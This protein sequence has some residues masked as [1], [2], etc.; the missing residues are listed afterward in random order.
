MQALASKSVGA[1]YVRDAAWLPHHYDPRR[2]SLTFAYLP[3]DAQRAITFLDPRFI[4]R[5]AESG[6][7]QIAQLPAG[8]IRDNA[9][10]LQFIFHTGFCCST[11][12][13][14]ALDIPGI[15]MGL[16]EPAVLASFADYWSNSRRNVGAF[17][18]LSATVDLLSRP[19]TPGE[20]QVVKPSTIV[21]HIMP[22]LLHARQDAKAILLYSSLDSFLRAIARRGV[23]GRI[24]A[25]QMFRQFAPVNP[26]DSG[27]SDDDAILFSDLQVAA[28][29]WLMQISFMDQITKRF[30]VDRIRV[31]D[32]GTLLADPA[33]TL[34]QVGAFFDMN[35]TLERAQQVASSGI[36][37]EHAKELGR[38]F[39][40]AAQKA[41][42]DEAGA[43]HRE[44]LLM[45]KDWARALAIRSNAPLA[46]PETIFS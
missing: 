45:A 42:Y 44:E 30:G 5:S 17:E 9:G 33:R 10:P 4:E 37:R 13:T 29:A 11:L 26:L 18:A 23:E 28:Q 8:A 24:F 20:T 16:K 19:L 34:K 46:L 2:D 7:V 27:H 12:L 14:R 1:E 35:L 3:R 39:D 38:P 15:S 40:A 22:Q 43:T 25:R 41:Q 36:F 32:A 21:N 6:S 31:L